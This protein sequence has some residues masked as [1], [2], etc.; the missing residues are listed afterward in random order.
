MFESSRQSRAMKK[1]NAKIEA[2]LKTREEAWKT[3]VQRDRHEELLRWLDDRKNRSEIQKHVRAVLKEVLGRDIDYTVFG[4]ANQDIRSSIY[5]VENGFLPSLYADELN[6]PYR[7]GA[8]G[9]ICRMTN[10]EFWKLR[11]WVIYSFGKRGIDI[12][13]FGTGK[14]Q[15][16][17]YVSPW[18][19]KGIS[20][21]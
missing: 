13:L 9:K 15:R 1:E 14:L 19:G 18:D 20:K 12:G 4:P 3:L 2:E 16:W 7:T 8:N 6:L 21:K 10:D 5:F 17:A 11:F